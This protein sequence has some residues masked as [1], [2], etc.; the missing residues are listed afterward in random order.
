M[1]LGSPTRDQLGPYSTYASSLPYAVRITKGLSLTVNEHE[2]VAIIGRSGE[3]KSVLLKQIIGLIKPD[4][5]SV[6]ID[7]DDVTK[8]TG[9]KLQSVNIIT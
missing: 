2:F 7:G 3:G 9:K 8:L 6:I 1:P 5:G 4:S